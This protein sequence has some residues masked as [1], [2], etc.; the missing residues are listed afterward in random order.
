M[1]LQH[2]GVLEHFRSLAVLEESVEFDKGIV[3]VGDTAPAAEERL[4]VNPGVPLGVALVEEG[5]SDSTAAAAVDIALDIR[6]CCDIAEPVD[7]AAAVGM[8]QAVVAAASPSQLASL[9]SPR[10]T[11]TSL[12]GPFFFFTQIP[13]ILNEEIPR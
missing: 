6:E 10:R 11:E 13:A 8:Q 7:L 2:V 3:V 12:I 1:R 4:Q 5:N 9:L